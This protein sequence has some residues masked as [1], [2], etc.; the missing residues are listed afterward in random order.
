MGIM[1]PPSIIKGV[2]PI[3]MAGIIGIYGLI[4]VFIYTKVKWRSELY[5]S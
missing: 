5:K 4:V 2:I 3:I 1:K